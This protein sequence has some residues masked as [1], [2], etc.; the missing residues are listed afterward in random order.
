[1]SPALFVSAHPDDETLA[2]GVAIA[3]HVA[4]GQDVHVLWLTR[5]EG[6]SVLAKLNGVGVNSWW[7]VVHSPADEGY[8]VLTVEQFGEARIAEGEAAVRCLASG[9]SGTLTT[10]EAQLPNGEVTVET[11]YDEILKVCDEIAPDA[12]VRLKGHTWVPQLDAHPDHI[13]TGAAIKQ[14]GTDDA[15][16]FGDRRFYILPPY[17]I[18]PDLS[19][20]TEAWDHPANAEVSA[21]VVN[22]VRAYSA[23]AP[24][25]RFAIAI[26]S[27]SGYFGTLLSAIKCL[28]H[29]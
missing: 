24:P 8:D 22:A 13:A 17:W 20:V 3:E 6:S 25:H 21:R 2:M 19:L 1:M 12:S 29:A 4:A 15:T 16:R 9:Y 10:H 18:D 26:Q 23:W 28:F 7:G 5:G 27:T 14:L 11:A